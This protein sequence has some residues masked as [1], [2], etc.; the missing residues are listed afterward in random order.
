[1]QNLAQG[2]G[3]EA[4]EQV[5]LSWKKTRP[6]GRKKKPWI[7]GKDRQ[8]YTRRHAVLQRAQ[9]GKNSI[10]KRN[11]KFENKGVG[12]EL[13]R[14]WYIEEEIPI[15]VPMTSKGQGWG[16]KRLKGR[17]RRGVRQ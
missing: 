1:L 8:R 14:S 7:W 9:G 17:K 10:S 4:N 6:E 15:S 3:E 11:L 12:K 2:R 13:L 16:G 5:A